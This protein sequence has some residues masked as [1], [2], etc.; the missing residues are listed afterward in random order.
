M[1]ALNMLLLFL[2]LLASP[3]AFAQS[4]Y[5]LQ[6]GDSVQIWVDQYADM[7]RQV[8]LAPDG[9]ISL[10]LVGSVAAEG[11]S[12]E[13]LEEA[14]IAKLQPF[15]T[16]AVSLNVSL[17][18]SE[19]NAPSVFAAG[20]VAEPGVYPFRQGMT[21]LHVVAVAGGPYRSTFLAADQDRAIELESS[22][23]NDQARMAELSVTIARLNAQIA[24]NT[25]LDLSSAESSLP[26]SAYIEREQALL[27]MQSDYLGA[28]QDTLE[29]LLAVNQSTIEGIKGQIGSME[30]RIALSQ[31]RLA[32][33]TTLVERGVMQASQMRE[34]E[35]N[36]VDMEGTL[37]QLKSALSNQ[38]GSMLT[39]QA[40]V[41]GLVQ[42]YRVGLMTQL[43]AA[44]RERDTLI[45]R[46]AESRR[47]L[48]LYRPIQ[49]GE[50]SLRYSI[51]RTKDGSTT[52]IDATEETPVALGDLVRVTRVAQATAA[53]P[54]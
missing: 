15:L 37:S 42:D 20:D 18:P 31:E 44:E 45:A 34:I 43:G 49:G 39:E 47:A 21:V 23:D 3:G 13:D 26:S 40:R 46:L 11:L 53:S 27:A 14:L 1:R 51:V 33:A 35:I 52:T 5:H 7:S 19:Q 36:I 28:Q 9:R 32:A 54:Q 50:T 38:Q 12:L 22:I 2:V 4:E 25:Q 10:P 6:P 16:E 8:A 41:D 30:Q 48:T 17:V 29:R 24:G